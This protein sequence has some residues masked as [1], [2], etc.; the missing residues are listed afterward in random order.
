MEN[1]LFQNGSVWLKADFH[2]HTYTD[3]EFIYNEDPNEY[4]QKY[5]E[6]LKSTNTSIGIVTNHNKF[7]KDEFVKLK[8]AAKKEDIW[9]I[10]GIEFS[11]KEGIHLLIAFEDEWYKGQENNITDF[12]SSAFYGIKNPDIPPYP[13]S[14]FNIKETVEALDKIGLDYFLVIAHP[15]GEN[16]LFKVLKGRTLEAFIQ[17]ESFRNVIALQKSGNKDNYVRLCELAKREITCVEGS[18]NA[19]EGIEGIGRKYGGT[20]F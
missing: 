6:K 9:L 11:L 8:K 2:L 19:H 13:N 10:G 18:D 14:N 17:D 20:A 1:A 7:D 15:D 5:I 16:G 4:V 12:I 3:K